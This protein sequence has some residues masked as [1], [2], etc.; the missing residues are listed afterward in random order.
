MA[1]IKELHSSIGEYD[2]TF[3]L[4]YDTMGNIYI[5]NDELIIINHNNLKLK[6]VN[7]AYRDKKLKK[8]KKIKIK[9]KKIHNSR[10][11]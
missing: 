9:L 7:K 8:L 6:K 1:E 3:P 2:F 5:L 11:K 10:I 4:A